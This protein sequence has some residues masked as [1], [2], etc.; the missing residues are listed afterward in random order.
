[1]EKGAHDY[2]VQFLPPNVSGLKS[3]N[4][5]GTATV[6]ITEE[7]ELRVLYVQGA[8]TWD[9]KFVALALSKDPSMKLTGLTRT[10]KQSVF[11]QNVESAGEL[12]NGLPTKLDELAPFRVIVLSNLKPIDLTPA[13]QDLLARFCSELGGGVLMIG[14]PATFDFSWQG[15]RLEQLLPVVFSN[16][17]GVQ[18]LDRPF[19]LQ[20]TEDALPHPA[21]LIADHRPAREVWAELPT[22]SQYGRVDAAKPG[23]QIWALHEQDQAPTGR[24]ILMASQRYGAG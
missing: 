9:Y 14:G 12:L 16:N 24:R 13:Q 10:S 21:F 3:V 1:K 2:A 18:G 15:S 6:R 17:P 20:L 23:A 4:T 5:I 22:F 11:R 8:L 19:R 7:K